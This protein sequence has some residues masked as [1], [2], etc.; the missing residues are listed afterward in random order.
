MFH[1]QL[2]ADP[3]LPTEDWFEVASKHEGSWCQARRTVGCLV[4]HVSSL[5][6]HTGNLQAV[7]AVSL[8]VMLADV[9]GEPAHALPRVTLEGH[10]TMLE[11][12]STAW[13]ACGRLGHRGHHPLQHRR[14]ARP[15][16]PRRRAVH[17]YPLHPRAGA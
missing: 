17:R 16:R 4:I 1:T 9:R 3:H 8:L 7:P 5:A 13:Q 15:A 10:A 6:A 2:C 12:G 14:S 11:P